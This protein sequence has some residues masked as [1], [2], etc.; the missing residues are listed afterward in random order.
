MSLIEDLLFL[1]GSSIL[2]TPFFKPR[3]CI[4]RRD[5][6]MMVAFSLHFIEITNFIF[7]CKLFSANAVMVKLGLTPT[8][9]GDRTPIN[10]IYKT[11][12]SQ[13]PDDQSQSHL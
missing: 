11:F 8:F 9:T 3:S 5:D 13:K 6:I 10:H 4:Q 12:D 1:S 2:N 7:F